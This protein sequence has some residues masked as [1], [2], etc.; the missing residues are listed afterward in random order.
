MLFKESGHFESKYKE[1]IHI[2]SDEFGVSLDDIEILRGRAIVN[3]ALPI[4]RGVNFTVYSVD[5]KACDML[6]FK[7]GNINP[8]ARISFPLDFMVGH[9]WNMFLIG[10]DWNFYEYAY[11]IDGEY[12][13]PKGFLFD[14]NNALLDPYAFKINGR[15]KWGESDNHLRCEMGYNAF[16]WG[17]D[18]P[19]NLNIEDILVYEMHVRGFTQHPTSNVKNPGTFVGII[20]KIPYLLSLGVTAVELMPVFEFD[21]TQN[22]LLNPDT[23]ESLKNYWGYS[24]VG[25]FAPKSGYAVD[26]GNV[27][28]ELKTLVKELHKNGIEVWL[29]VVFNHTAEMGVDG[30]VIS[31]RGIDNRTYYMLDE[32]GEPFNFSGCGNTVNCNNPIVREFIINCL[33]FWASEYHIDGFRFDLASILSRDSDGNMLSNPPLI[34]TMTHDVLLA[35]C[36]LVAEPW[37]VG[38]FYQLGSFYT[39]RHWAEWNDDY[40]DTMRRFLRGDEG[41]VTKVV[42]RIMGSPD[43]YDHSGRGPSSSVNFI[44]CHDGFT[45]MDL[46]SYNEKHNRMNGEENRDGIDNNISFNF[47]VEGPT[48]DCEINSLREKMVKNALCLLMLS[49]G[50]PMLLMGDECL[51]TQQGNNN[52]YCQDNEI[53]WFN[54]ESTEKNN[55]VINFFRGMSHF[56]RRFHSLRYGDYVWHGIDAYKPDYSPESHTIAFHLEEIPCEKNGFIK[57]VYVA[58]NMYSRPLVFNPPIFEDFNHWQVFCETDSQESLYPFKLMPYINDLNYILVPQQSIT[59]LVSRKK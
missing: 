4:G 56:R 13:P 41:Q 9:C 14:K 11:S 1:N 55:H 50:V 42:S 24:T 33:R 43:I 52:A 3:G 39:D 2:L 19:L 26:P 5:G 58:I 27:I 6:V 51:R 34:E 49:H 16:D 59:I 25:F 35:N 21:E 22:T 30:P 36:K 17:E 29:D 32:N 8:C 54:W 45:L 10:I 12:D 44:C 18:R 40:R 46:F 23:G 38:G 7:K 47:G 20:E 53:S 15:D 28:F 31:F 48:D 37:D 57:Y